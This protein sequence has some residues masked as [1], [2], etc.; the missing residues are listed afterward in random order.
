MPPREA[1]EEDVAPETASDEYQEPNFPVTVFGTQF[2]CDQARARIEAI[3]A[4]RASKIVHTVKV[5][6]NQ[7]ESSV[8]PFVRSRAEPLYAA[9]GV[10]ASYIPNTGLEIKGDSKDKCQAWAA[11]LGKMHQQIKLQLKSASFNIAKRQHRFLRDPAASTRL[12]EETGFVVELPPT[13]SPEENVLLRGIPLAKDSRANAMAFVMELSESGEIGTVDLLQYFKGAAQL[14][15]AC[16]Y[17]NRQPHV[18]QSGLSSGVSVDLPTRAQ[19]N[20]GHAE[21][22]VVANSVELLQSAVKQVQD[23]C[24]LLAQPDRLAAVEVDSLHHK[25]LVPGGSKSRQMKAVQDKFTG[26]DIIWPQNATT[27]SVLVAWPDASS[28]P[29]LSGKSLCLTLSTS[30]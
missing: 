28:T 5:P 30:P 21:L 29:A 26:L 7:F 27:S 10:S 12:F 22:E 25:H 11:E 2:S 15:N 14:T 20:N 19:V 1:I 16:R 9:E 13:D 18:L 24:A 4:E 8:W 3:V 23:T 6:A 17:F